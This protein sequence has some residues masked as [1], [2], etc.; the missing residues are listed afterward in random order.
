M[1]IRKNKII[2]LFIGVALLLLGGCK[3]YEEPIKIGVNNWPPCELWYIAQ[4]KGYF[5]DTPVEIIRFSTWSDN[6][7]SLYVGKTDL[8]HST[9]FN[10]VYYNSRGEEAKIILSSDMI[11]GADG[12]VVKEDIEDIQDLR[13][14]R[15]AVE[16][17]TDEHFLLN[18]VLKEA[19]LKEEEV[20][21]VPLD[22]E[23][24]MRRFIAG[25][26]DSCFTYE[27]FLSQAA[28]K[29]RGE[30]ITSTSDTLKIID[31]LVARSEALNKRKEDY[32]NI[33]R[34]WYRAQEF[35]RD[36]PREAYEIMA[37]LEGTPYE[38][39]KSFYES[40][41]FFTLKENREIFSSEIFKSELEGIKV[42]L[43]ESNLISTD[44]DTDKL[45]DP[46]IVKSLGDEGDD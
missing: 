16:V 6:M 30:I 14:R 22:S 9:Y 25:E 15:I 29:G 8:T 23:E 24:G 46:G 43:T 35:V 45:F 26:V 37:A 28:E 41:Y 38:D 10:A 40:F 3:S 34:A 36:N 5:D 4:E 13:G 33:L 21:I 39:F 1:K 12:L 17:G 2:N 44:L 27:P 32:V 20:T 42:F 19:G 31:T 11:R 18:K 7:A